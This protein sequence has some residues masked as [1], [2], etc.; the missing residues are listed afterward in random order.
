M[1]K[2]GIRIVLG[3]ALTAVALVLGLVGYVEA[4]W[5]SH[6]RFGDAP[7]PPIHASTDPAVIERGRALVQGVAHCSS[8]HGQYDIDHPEVLSGEVPLGGGNAI[9]PP[10][11]VFY[12]ANITS[13]RETGIG[14]WTDEEIAR[15][16]RTG[17]RRDGELSVFMK[18]TV[19]DIGDADLTAIVSYLR[20]LPAIRHAV[21]PSEPNFVGR[22]LV[23]FAS[24][25]PDPP[26]P[27]ADVPEGAEP[28]IERGRY[29]ANGPAACV[30][31]HSPAS[32]DDPLALDPA[33]RFSGGHP[34]EGHR[35]ADAEVEFAPANLTSDPQTGATGRMTEDQWVD[36]FTTIGRTAT[37]SPMAWEGYRRLSTN[38]LRSIYRYLRTVPAIHRDNGPTSRTIGSFDAPE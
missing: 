20:S 26:D 2:W 9:R 38:D 32:A 3:G 11:G 37:G 1:K 18:L 24:I 16:I 31:C 5:S 8:C 28:S 35:P 15:V 29:L 23:T 36:R 6:T 17:V 27:V 10:F 30:G 7:S 4:S 33:R 21:P 12:A 14:A 13:D 34:M 25:Q 19:G 22:A